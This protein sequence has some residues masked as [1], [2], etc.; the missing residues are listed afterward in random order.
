MKRDPVAIFIAALRDYVPD[1][2]RRFTSGSCF[3]LFLL[4]RAFRP[5]VR[6]WYAPPGH[7]YTEVDGRFYDI[8]GRVR[9]PEGSYLLTTERRILLGAFRWRFASAATRLRRD[10]LN[11]WRKFENDRHREE[12]ARIA[13][14]AEAIG[15]CEGECAP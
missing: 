7:V 5:D 2:D 13:R 14:E 9:L 4:I 11:R 1:A 8:N 15:L 10:R 6:A 12:L 3:G